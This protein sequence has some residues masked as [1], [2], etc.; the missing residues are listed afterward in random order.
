[1]KKIQFL[2][3]LL[4]V[5]TNIVTAQKNPIL[6]K[7]DFQ[8]LK[9]LTQAIIDSSKIEP[10]Q[11]VSKDFGV[12]STGGVL[13]RPGGGDCYPSFW[14][15]DYAMSINT[16]MIEPSAQ[17]HMLLLTA[18]TQCDQ[19]WISD[20]GGMIPQ[21]AIADHIRIDDSLP[22]YYPGTY[23]FKMQGNATWGSFPPYGDQYCF[24]HMAYYYVTTTHKKTILSQKINGR[25]LFDRLELAFNVPPT[26]L[27]SELVFTNEQY[28]G[29]DFGFRDAIQITGDLCFP[30]ILKCKAAEEMA[31]LSLLLG[32]NDRSN[33][34]KDIASKIKNQ[35]TKF[36]DDKGML[37]ASTGFSSQTDVWSTV[38][39]IYFNI[40]NEEDSKKAAKVLASAYTE[41]T[42]AYKG[43]IRHVITS[44]DFSE[45]TSW[46]KTYVP[47]NTYQ[48]G[49]YWGTPTGWVCYAISLVDSSLAAKL[50][51]EYIDGLRE[52][53]VREGK[54]GAPYECLHPSGYKQNPLYMTTVSCPFIVF[55]RMHSSQKGINGDN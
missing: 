30:S 40:L 3:Y 35:I 54:G 49:S 50:A 27:G 1:M 14:I 4:F 44:D 23:D 11:F 29:V 2:F 21:G 41:G 26:R 47:K 15:R 46:E 42:L 28:R 13:I 36:K 19:T 43:N 17:E 20:E 16:G 12:N 52:S 24:I 45:Q 33:Y 55:N 22:I 53:D 6:K 10:G 32:L 39:A 25:T 31:E 5:V 8:Y 9:Q 48:N 7:K 38:L 18:K 34:Y 37:R 51:K